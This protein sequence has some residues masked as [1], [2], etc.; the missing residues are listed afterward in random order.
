[1]LATTIE[2]SARLL[3]CGVPANTADMCYDSGALSLMDYDSALHER[4]SRRETYEIIPAWSLNRLLELLPKEIDDEC[5]D[6]YFFSLAKEFPLSQEY[7]AAYIPCWDKG[8][9]VVRKHDNCPI[10][11]CVQLIEW[12]KENNY[13]LNKQQ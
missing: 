5:G 7:S 11:A 10:E 9:A 3:H 1:M 2:M 13:K 6:S 8:D 12:F 4:D